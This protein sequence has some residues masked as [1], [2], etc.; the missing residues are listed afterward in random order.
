MRTA[1]PAKRVATILVFGA[2]GASGLLADDAE[3]LLPPGEP[4][5]PGEVL[6][7]FR[8]D[9]DRRQ[10]DHLRSGLGA[11]RLRGF[12]GGGEHLVLGAGRTTES[13]IRQLRRHPLVVYAEP[14]YIVTA[15]VLPDDPLLPELYGMRNVGQ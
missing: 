14:N 8:E 6:I 15:D 12:R 4:Y 10:V 2:L 7:K 1:D 11:R 5:V 3:P 9:A 13:A